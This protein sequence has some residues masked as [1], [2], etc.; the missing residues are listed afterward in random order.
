M[1]IINFILI[2]INYYCII[3]MLKTRHFVIHLNMRVDGRCTTKRR[4]SCQA[5]NRAALNEVALCDIVSLFIRITK[6]MV[7]VF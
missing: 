4:E 7:A 6:C 2:F 3:I 1:D 5:G